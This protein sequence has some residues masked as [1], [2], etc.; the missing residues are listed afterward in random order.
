MLPLY[1]DKVV[2]TADG[3]A[4]ATLSTEKSLDQINIR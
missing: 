2:A 1:R 4:V 3:S